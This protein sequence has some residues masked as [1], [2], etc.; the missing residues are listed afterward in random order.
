[1]KTNQHLF[2]LFSVALLLASTQAAG[3]DFTNLYGL[4]A[5]PA[6]ET[7]ASDKLKKFYYDRVKGHFNPGIQIVTMPES[8]EMQEKFFYERVQNHFNPTGIRI[9]AVPNTSAPDTSEAQGQFF[10]NRVKNY[11]NPAK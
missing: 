3:N 7:E 9:K 5:A 4:D 2:N 10:Y 6:I 8:P 11:F 1:M